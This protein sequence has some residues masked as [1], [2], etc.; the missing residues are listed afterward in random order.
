MLTVGAHR[1]GGGRWRA[2]VAGFAMVVASAT[3]PARA[4]D[5]T[6]AT[7]C[8]R[9]GLEAERKSDLPHGL[10]HAIGMVESGRLAPIT[11]GTAAW[12]WTIN[13]NGAGHLFDSLPQAVAATQALQQHGVASVDVGCFQINLQQHP[14]AFASLEEAFDPSANATYAARFLSELRART[15]SWESAIAAYHSATPRLGG[16]YRDTVLASLTDTGQAAVVAMPPVTRVAVWTPSTATDQMRVWRPSAPGSAPGIIVIRQSSG[17]G[18]DNPPAPPPSGRQPLPQFTTSIPFA[19]KRDSIQ[20]SLGQPDP[21]VH[22][23]TGP[24]DTPL[25]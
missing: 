23:R 3:Q 5:T 6:D 12:P 11:G 14:A 7:A 17:T 8:E 4:D 25:R 22:V 13:A 20:Y 16:P 10:L 24:A 19:G 21:V 9:A 15:G 1:A 18:P 2:V